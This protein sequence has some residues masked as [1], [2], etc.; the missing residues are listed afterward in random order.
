MASEVTI[1][2][3][4]RHEPK[5]QSRKVTQLLVVPVWWVRLLGQWVDSDKIDLDRH[6]PLEAYSR[7][8]ETVRQV[9]R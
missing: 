6:V 8:V 1:G 9:E 4:G 2:A 7:P 5:R 3:D